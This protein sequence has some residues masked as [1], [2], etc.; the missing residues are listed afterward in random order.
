[1]MNTGT[2]GTDDI[3]ILY[4]KAKITNN[5]EDIQ[6]EECETYVLLD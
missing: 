6:V 5:S 1:M 2:E 3:H 4:T